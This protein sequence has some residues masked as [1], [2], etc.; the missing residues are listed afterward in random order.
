ME[1]NISEIGWMFSGKQEIRLVKVTPEMAEEMLEHNTQN[2]A[3]RKKTV[4]EYAQSIMSGNWKCTPDAVAFS[5]D[6][7]L[8]NGQHRLSAVVQAGIP[9]KMFVASGMEQSEYLDRGAKRNVSDNLS[10][11]TGR[12][13][14]TLWTSSINILYRIVHGVHASTPVEQMRGLYDAARPEIEE[15]SSYIMMRGRTTLPYGAD[16]RAAML[17]ILVSGRNH[18]KVKAMYEAFLS[19]TATEPNGSFLFAPSNRRDS[20]YRPRYGGG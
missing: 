10:I 2:R 8:I 4:S 6:G 1:Q 12:M 16:L 19:G 9:V 17:C 14:D 13:F 7:T 5:R 15:L 18:D 3:I 11:T 20:G